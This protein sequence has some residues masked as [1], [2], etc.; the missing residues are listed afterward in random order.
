[1]NPSKL[2]REFAN[3]ISEF[4]YY[5][6][7]IIKNKSPQAT[8][9]EVQEI[10]SNTIVSLWEK[11]FMFLNGKKSFD[12]SEL[13]SWVSRFTQNNVLWYFSKK[14]RKD[15]DIDF[16]SEKFDLVS[17]FIGEDNCS[18]SSSIDEELKESEYY[19][20]LSVLDKEEKNI[21]NLMWRGF[22][23]KQIGGIF[24]I[25]REAVRLKI[26]AIRVKLNKHFN[27][28]SFDESDKNKMSDEEKINLL[29]SII[30]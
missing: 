24:D 19:R 17:K 21:F 6:Q 13:K 2:E 22:S 29:K 15:K 26:D 16:N 25:T 7:G 20:Y 9:N 23:R 5:M 10:I 1:M 3:S 4:S 12:K 8:E 14:K 11:R 30:E 18:L 28:N 27:P